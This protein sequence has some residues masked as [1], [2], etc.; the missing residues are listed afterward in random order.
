MK[1]EVGLYKLPHAFEQE[2]H[3]KTDNDEE[4]EEDNNY[5]DVDNHDDYNDDLKEHCS[6]ED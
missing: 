3:R 6:S 2:R 5:E 4:E 1:Q